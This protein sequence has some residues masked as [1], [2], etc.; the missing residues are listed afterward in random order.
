MSSTEIEEIKL[1]LTDLN[2]NFKRLSE[3]LDS[4]EKV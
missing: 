4:R 2:Q 3:R 1:T